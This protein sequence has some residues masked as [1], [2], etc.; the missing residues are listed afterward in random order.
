MTRTADSSIKSSPKP[1]LS[2]LITMNG[3]WLTQMTFGSYRYMILPANIATIS[4]RFGKSLLKNM[5]EY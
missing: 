3:S 2:P 1:S 5:K 4:L